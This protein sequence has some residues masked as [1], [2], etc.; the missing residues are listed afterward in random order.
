MRRCWM[1]LALAMSG[2]LVGA[3]TPQ[4]VEEVMKFAAGK[5]AEYK[6]WSAEI[7]QSMNLMGVPLT[8]RGQTWFKAP[9]ST[10][11]EME[12]PMVGALGK[13]TMVMGNDGIMWQEMDLL[14]QKKVT[15]TNMSLVTSNLTA[16]SGLQVDAL[17]TPDPARQWE[18]NRQFMDYVLVG[19]GAVEGQPTWVLEATWKPE[20][21]SN[22]VLAQQVATVGKMR[23]HIGQQDGFTHRL[24]QFGKTGNTPVVTMDFRKIK[25]NE[26]LDDALFQYKPP[27]GI[28][29]VDITD[30]SLQLLQQGAPPPL[31]R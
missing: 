9:R 30:M 31:K 29:A 15:K 27:A 3:E 8:L 16:R 12:M 19:S 7:S 20:A 25:F 14:G 18:V 21:A 17:Q 1:W 28:E 24:E 5:S 23:L 11:T 22:P 13:M 26:Q 2:L 6:T 4:T 10:R